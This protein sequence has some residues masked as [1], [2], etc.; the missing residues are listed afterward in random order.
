[1]KVYLEWDLADKLQGWSHESAVLYR[2]ASNLLANARDGS[3]RTAIANKFQDHTAVVDS[4]RFSLGRHHPS[5]TMTIA[6]RVYRDS[7]IVVD[8][9]TYSTDKLTSVP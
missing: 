5:F 8:D 4:C 6:Y 3:S 9:I 7:S 2:A 1:M